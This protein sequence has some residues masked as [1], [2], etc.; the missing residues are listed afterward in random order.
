MIRKRRSLIYYI[1]FTGFT[2]CSLLWTPLQGQ[3]KP[4]LIKK[5]MDKFL[6]SE[7]KN[8]RSSSIIGIPTLGYSQESGFE[9][10]LGGVYNFYLNKDNL[11]NKS[12]NITANATM[13]TKKQKNIKVEA[14][15][16]TN[17]ND[18]H[19]I[20]ELRWRDWP[21]NFYGLGMHTLEADN[22]RIGQKMISVKLE[23][24]KKV[25]D[26]MYAGLSLKY[27]NLSYQPTDSSFLFKNA[28]M[29]G[30]TGGQHFAFGPIFSFDNRNTNTYTTKGLYFRTLLNFSPKFWSDDDFHGR[31]FEADLRYFHPLSKKIALGSQILYRNTEG[32]LPPYYAL[33]PLGGSKTMRGYYEGR[34]L[35]K[36]YLTGQLEV[37]YRPLPRFGLTAFSGIGSTFSKEKSE[38]WV[39]SVGGGLR[40]FYSLEHKGTLRLDYAVGEKRPGEKR[41]AGFYL[42]IS[43]AF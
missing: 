26:K 17:D 27:E 19:F 8:D 3:E 29:K 18:Y 2:V 33:N 32:D 11:V 37:R 5:L 23:S 13:T 39:G 14:D 28:D 34:Y 30:K 42:S 10:G 1:V 24:E 7:S 35:D 43:E 41:Q 22:E 6:S 38:R 15:I 20:S 12:S 16:W 36:N 9:Y 21:F 40:Y 25:M 31:R 4:G